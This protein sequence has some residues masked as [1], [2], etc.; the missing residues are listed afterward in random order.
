M[1]TEG[2]DKKIRM[3][4]DVAVEELT[5][6]FRL[7]IEVEDEVHK[8]LT[9]HDEQVE[10]KMDYLADHL[11]GTSEVTF[12]GEVVRD[13]GM[14]AKLGTLYDAHQNGGLNLKLSNSARASIIIA[15]IAAAS[16]ILVALIG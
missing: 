16:S 6:E 3:S 8:K 4:A 13:G 5:E 1:A 2:S 12:D 14:A 9:E 15:L 10:E 11:F 7:H